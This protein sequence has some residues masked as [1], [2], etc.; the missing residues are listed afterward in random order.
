MR[1]LKIIFILLVLFVSVSVQA[2]R[3]RNYIYLLDC[4]KSMIGYNGSPNIWEGTKD[5]LEEDIKKHT[6]GTTLHIVPFQEKVLQSYQTLAEKCQWNNIEKDLDKIVQ[7]VT[8]TN[9][10]AA[11]DAIDGHLDK[12]KDN[13]VILLTDGRDNVKGM[14]EVVKK[15]RNWC[16]K[17]PNT[18][19]FYVLLTEAAIDKKVVQVINLCDNEFI[20]D[21]SKGKIP[22]FGSFDKELVIYANTLNLKKVHKITFSSAGEYQAKTVCNDDYFDVTIIDGKIKNGIVSVQISAKKPIA[23]INAEL[24]ETYDF[25]FDVRSNEVEI[26]NPTVKVQMTNKPERALETLSEETDMGKATWYDSFLFWSAKDRDTLHVDLKAVFNEEAIKDHAMVKLEIKDIDGCNDYEAFLNGQPLEK[27]IVTLKSDE[28]VPGILSL[29]FSPAAREG[30]RYVE[31]KAKAA[32]QLDKINDTPV[33][34]YKLTLRSKYTI[35]WNPLKTIFMWIGIVLLAALFLWFLLFK[36]FIYPT[37]TVKY[38]QINEPYFSIIKVK[39]KRRVVFTNKKRNQGII[40]RIF[41]G[42]ILYMTNDIWTSPLS[43]EPGVKK[44]TLRVMR[45]NNYVFEPFSSTLT[46]PGDYV[47]EN[48]EGKTKIKMRIN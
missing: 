42:E 28:K 15:L 47:V 34:D 35:V 19:A 45:T 24:P 2:Q 11:W 16:G 25:T 31:L 10:C 41:T 1:L 40:S 39:G 44:K 5:Y 9:I 46:A 26:I 8:N 6:S 23:D 37:I 27:G 48:V 32:S 17:Y 38:I 36:H 30:A 3:E 20:V 33:R 4:T 14:D 12:Y 29:V 13:Y 21:A 43:F 22:V 7:N 18:Y